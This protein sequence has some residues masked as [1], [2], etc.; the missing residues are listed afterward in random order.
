MG[1]PLLAFAAC[2]VGMSPCMN[3][4]DS[5]P[6]PLARLGPRSE[7]FTAK[8][9]AETGRM[10]RMYLDSKFGQLHVQDTGN[11]EDPPIICL[12][13]AG[14]CSWQ[15]RS[16]ATELHAKGFRVVCPDMPGEGCTPACLQFQ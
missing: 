15:F 2:F 6:K 3:T 13:M 8:T 12:H 4:H 1:A 14:S 16:V 11:E 9:F 10:R 7:G 5:H